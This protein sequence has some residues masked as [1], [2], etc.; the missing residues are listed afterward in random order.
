MDSHKWNVQEELTCKQ[1]LSTQ[2]EYNWGYPINLIVKHNLKFLEIEI[3]S[4]LIE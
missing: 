1:A 3:G 4:S 2:S